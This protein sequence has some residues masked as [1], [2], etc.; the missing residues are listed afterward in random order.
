MAPAAPETG[1]ATNGDVALFYRR[2]GQPGRAPVLVLHGAG[3]YDSADWIEVG[4][5]L[6]ADGREVVAFDARGYGRSSWSRSADYSLDAQLSDIAAVTDHLG[7]EAPVLLG[8]SRGGAF[9]LRYAA[10][11][12]ERVGAAIFADSCPGRTARGPVPAGGGDAP[13]NGRL[14]PPQYPHYATLAEGL[15]S[16]SRDPTSLASSAKR[17]RLE[18]FF[19]PAPGGGGLVLSAR[20]PRFGSA[21][22]VDDSGWEP[23]FGPIDLWAALA[24]LPMPTLIIRATR[25]LAFDGAS[26]D[27]V[28]AEVGHAGYAEIDSGHDLAG[29]APAELLNTVRRFLAEQT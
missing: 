28:R 24:G 18:Q 26:V 7:W 1:F 6:A 12:P 27:R 14:G 19:T 22:P 17:A 3:Y 13:S 29:E 9:T 23:R 21:R 5:A 8:H 16:T 20:D 11:F 4:T 25:S 15:A 10:A 2:F